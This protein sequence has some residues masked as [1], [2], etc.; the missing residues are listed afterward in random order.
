MWFGFVFFILTALKQIHLTLQTSGPGY[1]SLDPQDMILTVFTRSVQLRVDYFCDHG[2]IGTLSIWIH[3]RNLAKVRKKAVHEE[4]TNVHDL[5]PTVTMEIWSVCNLGEPTL[6]TH[7]LH[8]CKKGPPN[9]KLVSVWQNSI[10]LNKMCLSDAWR[11]CRR[12]NVALSDRS[13]DCMGVCELWLTDISQP[14]LLVM[15]H[16]LW[17]DNIQHYHSLCPKAR[18]Q[19][20]LPH[21]LLLV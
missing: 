1:S 13:Q 16:L 3:I 15:T 10:H 20:S 17:Q 4:K 11:G 21:V 9:F 8:I 6:Y 7:F 12:N 2:V 18:I 14:P 5:P 19:T